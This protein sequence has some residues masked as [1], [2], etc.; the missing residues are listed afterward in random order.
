MQG[1][2]FENKLVF[3]FMPIAIGTRLGYLKSLAAMQGFLFKNALKQL[4]YDSL[5]HPQKA[6]KNGS[7]GGNHNVDNQ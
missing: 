6:E 3:G 4:L 1:I 2:F 5:I 7:Q